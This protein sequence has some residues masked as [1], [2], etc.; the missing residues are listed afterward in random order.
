M[1]KNKKVWIFGGSGGIGREIVSCFKDYHGEVIAP[2]HMQIDLSTR[3]GIDEYFTDTDNT[4]DAV[5]YSAGIN[6]PKPFEKLTENDLIAALKVNTLGFFSVCTHLVPGMKKRG[7]GRIVVLSS[8]YGIISRRGRLPYA[9]SKHALGGVVQTLAMELAKDNILVNAVSPG[10]IGTEMT[11]RNNSPE[12]VAELTRSIPMGRLGTGREI[13]ETAAFLCSSRNS[14]IT[15]Q[16]I[17]VDGGY[18]V[19]GWQSE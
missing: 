11:Y 3:E 8:L 12:K 10:F 19:G 7:G 1:F 14:Y 6:V 15:G 9:L 4:C 16:N 17:V 2:T 18:M 5:V 13:G